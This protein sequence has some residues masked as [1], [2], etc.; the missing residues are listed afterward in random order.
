MTPAAMDLDIW[1]RHFQRVT[2]AGFTSGVDKHVLGL[3]REALARFELL[4]FPGPRDEAWKY[5]NVAPIRSTDFQ[6]PETR[7]V[8]P[9]QLPESRGIARLVFVDGSFDR[10]L[11]KANGLPA[12]LTVQPLEAAWRDASSA[13]VRRF[14]TAIQD[15]D[16]AFAALNTALASSGAWIHCARNTH[17]TEPLE[18]L[19]VSTGQSATQCHPRVLIDVEEGASAR[20]I[21]DS[22][23]VGQPELGSVGAWT[24]LVT[25]VF[26]APNASL[27][28]FRLLRDAE[29][30]IHTSVL[31]VAQEKD[32]RFTS[33]VFCFG[34]RLTRNDV[35]IDLKG[36]N[37]E[38][39]L[40]GLTIAGGSQHVDNHTHIVHAQP[41]CNSW[42]LYKAVLGGRATGVFN[43]KIYVAQD[44]QKT[45]AK[46]TN[47]SLLLSDGAT[48]DAKPELE[49][50][51]DDVKCT[52]GAT[53]GQLEES[54][55]FYLR[56]RGIGLEE[57]RNLL[58]YAFASDV[59]A[60]VEVESLRTLIERLLFEKLPGSGAGGA[61]R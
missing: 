58:T 44:A 15:E 48:M 54:A 31:A 43:G 61:L 37:I 14:G 21:E 17:V 50:Y 47:Q 4:G 9:E 33:H 26:V 7:R 52:H 42:E 39:T 36:E 13:A 40:N 41:H 1:R 57:A 2:E 56:S 24:N 10:S 23:H 34:G 51:A 16:Q 11:S 8:S 28:Q 32:S 6:F 27:E 22:I 18:I 49:I 55:L 5:T 19:F 30:A 12:G 20:V 53:I 35:R 59:V 29:A 25:E 38:S 3:R 46:Q 45:D 60:E